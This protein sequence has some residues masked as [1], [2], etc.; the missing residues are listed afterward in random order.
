MQQLRHVF[1]INPISGQR[2]SKRLIPWIEEYFENE[3]D[4]EIFVTEYPGHA[5]ELANRFSV[6]D[7]VCIYCVGGDG[8]AFEVLN[9]L[10][11]GVTM[12]LIPNGTGNDFHRSIYKHKYDLKEMLVKTI[13][14]QIYNIDFGVANEH[15][16]LNMFTVGFD[17]YINKVTV[18]YKDSKVIP[19]SL[20]YVA[21]VFKGLKDLS[22]F[23][24]RF[25]YNGEDIVQDAIVFAVM[26]G[27]YYGGGFNPAPEA[28]LTDGL[29]DVLLIEPVT[30]VTLLRLIGKYAKGRYKE[31]K[32]VQSFKL[33][34]F[35]LKADKKMVYTCD[36]EIF[37]DDYFVI[38]MME[39]R[40]PFK[41]PKGSVYDDSN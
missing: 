20:A 26:N 8:T 15:R 27:Q 21:G 22:K 33:R 5:T 13:E 17:A 1:I 39:K 30:R 37:E 40:L 31:L 4:Y 24:L 11:D 41:M 16:F 25:K 3:D 19:N 29:F 35:E 32:Q 18:Q 12:A 6:R 9:G 10:A 23:N 34:S 2:D 38:T 14:G 36:G 7:H 28:S